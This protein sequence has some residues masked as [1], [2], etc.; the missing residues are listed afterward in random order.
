MK[1]VE[2]PPEEELHQLLQKYGRVKRRI[3]DWDLRKLDQKRDYPP[4]FGEVVLLIFDEENRIALVRK[5]GSPRDIFTFPQG[6]IDAGEGVEKAAAREAKE[7]TGMDVKVEALAAMHIVNICFKS[8]DL[9]RWHFIVVCRALSAPAS[10]ED[11]EEIA[12]V[13][14]AELPPQIP[15]DW[16]LSEW[17]FWV[18]KDAGLPASLE[19]S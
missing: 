14:F 18:L 7:E 19:S 12:E 13:K 15:S 8:W 1:Y 3:V 2:K 17:Y 9:E 11:R 6:R 16:P 5:R 4:C 10:P